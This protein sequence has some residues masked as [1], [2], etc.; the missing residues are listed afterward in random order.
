MSRS[1]RQNLLQVR[2]EFLPP[3]LCAAKGLL[4]IRTEA[5]LLHAQVGSTAR[6]GER[7]GDDALQIVSRIVVRKVPGVGQRS[8]RLYDKDLAVQHAAPVTTKI[9][10][11]TH[12]RLEVVFHQ[13]LLDQVWLRERA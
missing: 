6:C 5:R 4:L 3:E 8:V 1:S 13:P 7:K 2:E 9:E 10:T 12:V 11:M